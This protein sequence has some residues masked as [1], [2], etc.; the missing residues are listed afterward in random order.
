MKGEGK[1]GMKSKLKWVE[2]AGLLLSF[3]SI[4]IHFFL[5]M[6]TDHGFSDHQASVTFFSWQPIIE[7]ASSIPKTVN[8]SLSSPQVCSINNVPVFWNVHAIFSVLVGHCGPIG[9]FGYWAE[10]SYSVCVSQ[11][12][13]SS[14]S[15]WDYVNVLL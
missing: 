13:R 8:S 5:A 4:S 9:R 15:D 7:S 12:R 14:W 1:T 2:L 10:I 3:L 6:F 11:F